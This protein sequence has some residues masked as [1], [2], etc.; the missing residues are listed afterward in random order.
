MSKE[1]K[2]EMKANGTV[3]TTWD[4]VFR[5]VD[6]SECAL[7]P[8]F[9]K[10]R[11]TYREVRRADDEE[12]LAWLFRRQDPQVPN[13]GPGN[14]DGPGTFQRMTRQTKDRSLK[15]DSRTFQVG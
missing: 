10:N 11:I 13:A 2:G 12:G 5:R 9:T 7:H 3:E 6:G 1:K 8:D 15:W 4:F 14:S